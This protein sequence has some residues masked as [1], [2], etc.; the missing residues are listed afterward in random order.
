ML[1][2]SDP[3]NFCP[4]T[5]LKNANARAA[6]MGYRLKMGMELEFFLLKRA[7]DGR[8]VLADDLDTLD[9][10][11]YDMKGITRSYDFISSLSKNLNGLGWGTT[12]TTTRTPTASSR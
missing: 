3:Y 12:P 8:I 7:A 11:C 1:F 2:R 6:K 5:I 4:R 9:Q 10:P